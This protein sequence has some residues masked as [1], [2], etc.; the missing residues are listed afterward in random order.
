MSNGVRHQHPACVNVEASQSATWKICASILSDAGRLCS[1]R[2]RTI[3][4]GCSDAVRRGQAGFAVAPLR[5]DRRHSYSVPLGHVDDGVPG[6]PTR[7][8]H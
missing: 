3:P 6:R 7:E 1:R 5:S 2:L 4:W 8:L